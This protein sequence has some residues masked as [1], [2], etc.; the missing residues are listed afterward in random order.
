[1]YRTNVGTRASMRAAVGSNVML[2]KLVGRGSRSLRDL[3]YVTAVSAQ[4]L[5]DMLP[6]LRRQ[7]SAHRHEGQARH[8]RLHLW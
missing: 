2:Y 6:V 3:L 8:R 5:R 4:L 7:G 1:M